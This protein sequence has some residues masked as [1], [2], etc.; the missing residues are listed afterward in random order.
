MEKGQL[1]NQLQITQDLL[2]SMTWISKITKIILILTE[3]G[4]VYMYRQRKRSQG[5][6]KKVIKKGRSQTQQLYTDQKNIT[7]PKC[8]AITVFFRELLWNFWDPQP[9]VATCVDICSTY[10]ALNRMYLDKIRSPGLPIVLTFTALVYNYL[11]FFQHLF[12]P[13]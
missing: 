10:T 1:L 7:Y 3:G 6:K 8:L 5:T 13:G 12:L 4:F 9:R 2:Y 11:Q